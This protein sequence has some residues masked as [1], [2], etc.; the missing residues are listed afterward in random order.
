MYPLYSP[1]ADDKISVPVFS[2]GLIDISAGTVT[3]AGNDTFNTTGPFLVGSDAVVFL[4]CSYFEF[5][6]DVVSKGQLTLNTNR[7]EGQGNIELSGPFTW[8]SGTIAGRATCIHVV[9][10][11]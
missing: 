4:N 6:L 5:A 11:S 8:F 9:M 10:I 3:F 7:L 1:I 2:T